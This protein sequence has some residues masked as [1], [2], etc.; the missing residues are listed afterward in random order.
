MKYASIMLVSLSVL[1]A[2]CANQ[3]RLGTH[4]AQLRQQQTYDSSATLANL[5]VIPSGSG[6][7]ME[8][9]YSAYTGKKGA[10][11]ED[12]STSQ[13]LADFN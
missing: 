3:H 6:E 4:V 9:A 11:I 13:V 1:L 10:S 8:D 2:G 12:A 5:E 7:R